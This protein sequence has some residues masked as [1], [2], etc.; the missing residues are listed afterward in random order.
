MIYNRPMIVYSDRRFLCHT[1][2]SDIWMPS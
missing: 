2:I 1:Y